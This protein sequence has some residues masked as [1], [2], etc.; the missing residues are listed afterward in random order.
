L[1]AELAQAGFGGDGRV[2]SDERDDFS[3]LLVE[4]T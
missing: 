1:T 2:F 4:R 3:V